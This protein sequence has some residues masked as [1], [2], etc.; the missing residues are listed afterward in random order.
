MLTFSLQT[1]SLRVYLHII[2][3]AYINSTW[4]EPQ[5]TQP[6]WTSSTEFQEP[7]NQL[8]FWFIGLCVQFSGNPVD[9]WDA[10]GLFR[11]LLPVL[12]HK[13][14]AGLFHMLDSN[15]NRRD[16][17]TEWRNYSAEGLNYSTEERLIAGLSITTA[18][19]RHLIARDDR[20]V[21]L[22]QLN[23]GGKR[24]YHVGG[25]IQNA[26]TML[27][28][29]ERIVDVDGEFND[30]RTRQFL[31]LNLALVEKETSLASDEDFYSMF[32][33]HDNV[34]NHIIWKI[35]DRN[36]DLAIQAAFLRIPYVGLRGTN[37]HQLSDGGLP[38]HLV[39]LMGDS[40]SYLN[41]VTD[42]IL[43]VY[44]LSIMR[45]TP[46]TP[47]TA[48]SAR[49]HTEIVY[50]VMNDRNGAEASS[51]EYFRKLL[52]SFD[53]PFIK[54]K[55]SFAATEPTAGRSKIPEEILA[56]PSEV[57]TTNQ[58]T[59]DKNVSETPWPIH[60]AVEKG[61]REMVNRLLEL[62][63]DVNARDINDRTPLLIAAKKRMWR[64][65][66]CYLT[67]RRTLRRGMATFGHL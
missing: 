63:V 66:N 65:R 16:N 57:V 45:N 7:R 29:F 58:Q 24:R 17:S 6:P 49:G 67:T 52:S 43:S 11:L 53:V 19:V 8:W 13:E 42:R 14:A 50:K 21:Y 55:G 18:Y 3:L 31:E 60:Y 64:L 10:Q 33:F 37:L 54:F 61:Y 41:S 12:S 5:H 23:I 40:M 62:S 59:A 56:A 36:G 46:K 47:P 1:H 38:K 20:A 4:V 9:F 39:D 15:I 48:R 44:K 35:S 26:Q 30:T 22:R 27:G 25:L 34:R 51:F 2:T 32:Q 28:I